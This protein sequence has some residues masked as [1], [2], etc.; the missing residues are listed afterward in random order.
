[1]SDRPHGKLLTIL[2]LSRV[3][4]AVAMLLLFRGHDIQSSF[5]ILGLAVLAQVTDTLDGYIARHYSIPSVDGYLTDSFADKTC[6]FALTIAVCREY[7][8]AYDIAWLS[9]V[10]EI[11]LLSIRVARSHS[12]TQ[13]TA[14]KWPSL[15][16]AGLWRV[17]LLVLILVPVIESL[18]VPAAATLN[19][20][21]ICYYLGVPAGAFGIHLALRKM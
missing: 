19:A 11:A 4:I 20:A 6:H 18:G 16:Y 3:I 8:I 5:V 17:S 12:H 21:L 2:S 14:I 13:L 9:F 15:V 7:G 1:M 10:R